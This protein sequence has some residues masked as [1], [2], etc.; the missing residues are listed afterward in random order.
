MTPPKA[1]PIIFS[2]PMVQAILRG[3]KTETRRL[4]KPQPGSLFKSFGKLPTCT[5]HPYGFHDGEHHYR[6]PYGQPGDLLWVRETFFCNHFGYPTGPR[7][8]LL[9]EM[10]YRADGT[11]DFEGEEIYMRW[12]PSTHMPRWASRIL[13]EITDVQVEHLRD[14]TE[15]GAQREGAPQMH[16]D[17]LGGTW[18][19]HKRGFESIWTRL[20]G[21]DSWIANPWVWV[22]QFSKVQP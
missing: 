15:E 18:K 3:E 16:L 8:E 22:V 17:D 4:V 1:R 19:T 14:I 13:L 10:H 12:Q 11:P 7:E 9:E 20:H 2:A 5:C 6:S 21:E